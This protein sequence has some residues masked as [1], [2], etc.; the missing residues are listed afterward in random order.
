MIDVASQDPSQSD[1]QRAEAILKAEGHV[2]PSLLQRRMH[3]SYA[4]ALPL[5]EALNLERPGAIV[6]ADI[7]LNLKSGSLRLLQAILA[8]SYGS[9]D[10]G[11]A[12]DELHALLFGDGVSSSVTIKT[13]VGESS[14]EDRAY[15]AFH[16]AVGAAGEIAQELY[17]S[18]RLIVIVSAAPATLM[19]REIKIICAELHR[20]VDQ[21]CPISFGI[22]Y[23]DSSEK[24]SL[25]VAF[26]FSV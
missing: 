21:S 10:I 23:W 17:R 7:D 6:R 11:I 1:Y 26:M 9:K 12:D 18:K 25:S 14:G 2:T 5:V 24:D 16:N 8:G 19:G 15:R 13:A 4:F 3:I 20:R 22:Q